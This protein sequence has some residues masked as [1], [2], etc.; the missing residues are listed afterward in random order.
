MPEDV[1]ER[2]FAAANEACVYEE[3]FVPAT[4]VGQSMHLFC[5]LIDYLFAF[6]LFIYFLFISVGVTVAV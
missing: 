4:H 3:D 5:F 6:C 1:R 2:I